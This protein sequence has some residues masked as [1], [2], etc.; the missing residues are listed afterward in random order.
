MQR[1]TYQRRT[2]ALA[3]EDLVLVSTVC[4]EKLFYMFSFNFC[5]AFIYLV[6]ICVCLCVCGAGARCS[7]Y[8]EVGEEQ[9]L[10]AGSFL[11]LCGSWESNTGHEAWRQL[12]LCTESCQPCLAVGLCFCFVRQGCSVN[13]RLAL[14]LQSSCLRVLSARIMVM[15]HHTQLTGFSFFN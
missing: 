10:G 1:G 2:P 11:L 6:C 3:M 8:A 13:P 9:T 4:Y 14:I 5:I 15:V 12:A 7:S